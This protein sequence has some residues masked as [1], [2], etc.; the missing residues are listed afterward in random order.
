LDLHEPSI[1]G[2]KVELRCG[3]IVDH[4]LGASELSEVDSLEVTRTTIACLDPDV[5][6]RFHLVNVQPI[7]V[8]GSAVGTREPR[9]RPFRSTE[10]ADEEAPPEG[11][12]VVP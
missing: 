3:E 7:R 2:P 8:H 1:T 12:R 4:R 5:R 11:A 6:D 9:E 10:R